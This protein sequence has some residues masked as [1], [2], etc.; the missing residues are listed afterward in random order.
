MTN[1]LRLDFEN[2]IFKDPAEEYEDHYES[3][4]AES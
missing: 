4:N 1:Q 3:L 2:I